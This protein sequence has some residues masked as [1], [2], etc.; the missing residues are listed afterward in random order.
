M[1]A[2]LRIFWGIDGVQKI[3]T[4]TLISFSEM[5]T[6]KSGFE[7]AIV[8]RFWRTF[9]ARSSS[10]SGVNRGYIGLG[11]VNEDSLLTDRTLG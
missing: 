3:S 2:E 10:S 4:I 5:L 8:S 11:V 7:V 9:R 1:R 6:S